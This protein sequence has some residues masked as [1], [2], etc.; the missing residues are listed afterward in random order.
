MSEP[1]G[2]DDRSAEPNKHMDAVSALLNNVTDEEDTLELADAL[3]HG[4]VSIMAAF[5]IY[6]EHP[7]QALDAGV[8]TF[9]K[10]FMRAL[11]YNQA[12]MA[13]QN[14]EFAGSA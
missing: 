5:T 7:E 1:D 10:A 2:Q 8:E 9:L 12:A 13:L 11:K 14:S 3:L 6:H 4:L